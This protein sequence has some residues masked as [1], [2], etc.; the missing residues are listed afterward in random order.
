MLPLLLAALLAPTPVSLVRGAVVGED[1]RYWAVED[2]FLD[3]SDPAANFGRDDLLTV[4]PGRTLLIKFGDLERFVP[5]GARVRSARIVLTPELGRTPKL[6]GAFRMLVPWREGPNTR[7]RFMANRNAPGDKTGPHGAATWGSRRAGAG[8]IGWDRAGA[9]GSGDAERIDGV[10]GT[11][12][13][14]RFVIAGLAGTVQA[15]SERWDRND[16]FAFTFEGNCDFASSDARGNRPVLEL[17]LEPPSEPTGSAPDMCV[18]ALRSAGGDWYATIKNVGDETATMAGAEWWVEGRR[19]AVVRLEGSLPRGDSREI[20]LTEAEARELRTPG[21]AVLVRVNPATGERDVRNNAAR[22][23]VGSLRTRVLV[24]ESM[25]D[26]LEVLARARGYGSFGDLLL[27]TNRWMNEV[28]LPQSRFSFAPEGARARIEVE[29]VFAARAPDGVGIGFDHKPSLDRRELARVILRSAGLPPWTGAG[30]SNPGILGFGDTR[31]DRPAPQ[32]LPLTY[33]PWFDPTL[34]TPLEATDLL[35][36]TEVALLDSLQAGT[37]MGAAL[38][39]LTPKVLL[40]S[41][42]DSLNVPIPDA[43]VAFGSGD[44]SFKTNARGLA[45]IPADALGDFGRPWPVRV[46][47]GGAVEATEL[48]PWMVVDA[49]KRSGVTAALVQVRFHLPDGRIEPTNAAAGKL[50]TDATGRM[51]A[52][53]TLLTDGSTDRA[54]ELDGARGAW[55]EVDLGR[56]RPLGEVALK[57]R[58]RKAWGRFDVVVYATGQRPAEAQRWATEMD[59]KW[60][61]ARRSRTEDDVSELVYRGRGIRGRFIRIVS[62]EPGPPMNLAEIEVRL[63]TMEEPASRSN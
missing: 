40:L 25:R 32:Q 1:F 23:Y 42:R 63:L 44:F 55:V 9:T 62:L 59:A 27:T 50:V 33:G 56:D 13:G 37:T 24:A 18:E 53:L 48:E 3:S 41:V 52:Q 2:T 12:E 29:T 35:A 19:V 57:L 51:P 36:A 45:Q 60:A 43:E 47:K 7:N 46:R 34:A 39:Q 20:R 14:G 58:D 26:E 6:R 5:A 22:G 8:R 28:A 38:A 11:D 21:A 15:M 61:L 54:I 30:S 4:G 17:E 49:V 31:D 10:T 16:G